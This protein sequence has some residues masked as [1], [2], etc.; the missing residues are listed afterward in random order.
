MTSVAERNPTLQWIG[1][2]RRV[3][4]TRRPTPRPTSVSPRTEPPR[5]QRRWTQSTLPSLSTSQKT[6]PCQGT[7]RRLP[8][9]YSL[10][11]MPSTSES[12]Q[13]SRPVRLGS[14]AAETHASIRPSLRRTAARAGRLALLA[15]TP[16]L[17]ASPG[18]AAP[19]ATPVT[20]TATV[21][22]PMAARRASM[23]RAPAARA[24]LGARSLLP[25]ARSSRVRT[26][27]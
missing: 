10:Q 24:A 18:P 26:A 1:R 5:T 14:R 2:L 16:R 19:S 6:L 7:Q 23:T 17:S 13:G 11:R 4:I 20:P 21:T 8:R 12:M 3:K 25:S 15:L 9:T 22:R 27:V